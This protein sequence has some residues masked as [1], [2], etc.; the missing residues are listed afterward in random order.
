MS[1]NHPRM[2]KLVKRLCLAAGIKVDDSIPEFQI[3][4]WGNDF[5]LCT[6]SYC[7]A[8][9]ILVDEPLPKEHVALAVRGAVC[10]SYMGEDEDDPSEVL[11]CKNSLVRFLRSQNLPGGR[12][13]LCEF[14]L[15]SQVQAVK[16]DLDRE[17]I[18]FLIRL[19]ESCEWEFPILQE[20]DTPAAEHPVVT[21][22]PGGPDGDDT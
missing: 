10:W 4:M 17:L 9:A 18:A 19:F 14:A 8:L 11:K 1:V 5:L 22:T 21:V 20:R 7:L 16:E 13:A 12:D 3:E 2:G 6:A 15:E